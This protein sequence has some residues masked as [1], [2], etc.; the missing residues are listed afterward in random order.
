[1]SLPRVWHIAPVHLPAVVRL[2]LPVR[3]LFKQ[4][5]VLSNRRRAE[6]VWNQTHVVVVDV[7]GHVLEMVEAQTGEYM[8]PNRNLCALRHM[9]RI[10]SAPTGELV[11]ACIV[12]SYICVVNAD[13]TVRYA[14]NRGLHHEPVDVA[15]YNQYLVVL[16]RSASVDVFLLADGS[17]VDQWA[18]PKHSA[19]LV[20]KRLC[21][22]RQGEVCLVLE[23]T[24]WMYDLSGML[25]RTFA[26]YGSPYR[27]ITFGSEL[28]IVTPLL[29]VLAFRLSDGAPLGGRHA[30][31]DRVRFI[32]GPTPRQPHYLVVEDICD[33]ATTPIYV[34][35]DEW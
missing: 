14:F 22:S 13:G 12:G 20:P 24:V 10:R 27:A 26:A 33:K 6:C 5:L 34:L 30:L 3:P 1:M 8:M 19:G 31:R 29:N 32:P 17:R 4:A 11:I 28:W 9:H 7:P 18:G 35:E 15:V 2:Y 21:I 23:S 25:L 16:G